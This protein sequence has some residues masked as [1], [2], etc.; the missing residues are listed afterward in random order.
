M[1]VTAPPVTEALSIFASCFATS[2]RRLMT[3]S[4]PTPDATD[5]LPSSDAQDAVRNLSS[6]YRSGTNNLGKEFFAPCLT[7][8]RRY[9]RAVGYFSSSSLVTWSA[10]LPLLVQSNCDTTIQLLISPAL[11]ADDVETLRTV[12]TPTDRQH[13]LQSFADRIAE[14]AIALAVGGNDQQE[15]RH[16]LLAWMLASGRLELRFA[17]PR[18]VQESGLF[19]EK[20]GIF[21]FLWGDTVAFTGSANE[22]R[23]GHQSNYESIDVFRSWVESDRDRVRVKEEQFDEAWNARAAGL[24]VVALSEHA[25]QRIRVRAEEFDDTS[26][27]S[28]H[29]SPESSRWRHQDEAIQCF[30]KAQRGVLEMATGTGKTRTA[31]RILRTLHERQQIDSVIVAADGNDLLDQWYRQL[32]PLAAELGF[33]VTRRYRSHNDQEHFALKPTFRIHLCSRQRLPGAL[34]PLTDEHKARLLLIHD[35]VHRLGSPAN[36]R[37][38]DGLERGIIYRLGLSA[39]PDREYDADGNAFIEHHIGP[40]I[41]EFTLEKAIQRGILSPFDYYPLEWTASEDDRANIQRV[42]KQAAAR[43][44]SGDPMTQEEI[45]MRLASVYKTSMTKLPGFREFF[46]QRPERIKRSLVFVATHEYAQHV[47]PYIHDLTLRFHTYFEGD[48]K[49]VLHRFSSGQLDCLVT[50]HRLSEGI[51][52]QSIRTVVLLS[53]DRARLETIQRIGRCLRVDAVDPDKRASVVDFIRLPDSES[54][55]ENADVARRDWLSEVSKTMPE[56]HNV[57]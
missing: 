6:H 32:A 1:D 17:F 43:K 2:P 46:R 52:I 57:H 49:D 27:R 47:I 29:T 19:H 28:G 35:E 38:L 5:A 24:E 16:R 4:L 54:A 26:T 11:S 55:G 21:D 15:R 9:R 36:R 22:T 33:S 50:C 10:A 42:Y 37:D 3:G 12:A 56:E 7:A 30:L 48:K 45:W 13:V 14:D 40:T 44:A 20:I 18:H 34:L 8:C 53:A 41:Y 51:D 31:L 23:A 39:T 25:L